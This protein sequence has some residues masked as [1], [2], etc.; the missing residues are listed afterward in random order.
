ME[1]K[2]KKEKKEKK[3][4]KHEAKKRERTRTSLKIVV[5]QEKAFFPL[6]KR[7]FHREKSTDIVFI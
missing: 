5:E 2:G 7:D 3:R 1:K 6:R 4:E